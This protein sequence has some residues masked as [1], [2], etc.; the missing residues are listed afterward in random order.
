MEHLLHYVTVAARLEKQEIH[1]ILEQFILIIL[2][3]KFLN[4][5]YKL[6][7]QR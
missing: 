3:L 1:F 6:L 2:N 5:N 7:K 4:S